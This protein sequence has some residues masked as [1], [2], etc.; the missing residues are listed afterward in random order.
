[1][2]NAICD[3]PPKGLEEMLDRLIEAADSGDS[4]TVESMMEAVGRRS[5]GPIVLLV[6]LVAMSPLSGI[7]TI[8]SI[9]GIVVVLVAGQLLVGRKHFWI[10]KRLL[11]RSIPSDKFAK[12]LKV[13]LPAGRFVDRFLRPRLTFLT[14]GGGAYLMA[15]LCV[16]VGA[17]MPPLELLPF[18]ATTA[19][20]ALTAYGLALIAHDGML[21]LV[22]IGATLGVGYLAVSA[23]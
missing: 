8:P 1:M 14:R 22:A 19:G 12:A 18:L 5:F 11:R 15:V 7:P 6:G 3:E 21:A 17:T 13:L 2:E 10:P 4:V 20:A 9:L 16:L 23:L